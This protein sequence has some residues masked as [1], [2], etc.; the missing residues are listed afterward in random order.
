[1]K[2]E[3]KIVHAIISSQVNLHYLEQVRFSPHFEKDLKNKVNLSLKALLR[4]SKLFEILENDV[5]DSTIDV[6]DVFYDFIKNVNTVNIE[7]MGEIS[8]M[9]KAYKKDKKSI[10][11]IAK[12]ILT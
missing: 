7:E 11:G 9:I 4:H 6:H 8:G 10:I 1:M 5:E 12:K 2:P 3:E